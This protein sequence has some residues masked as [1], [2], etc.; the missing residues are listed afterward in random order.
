MQV[1]VPTP[2]NERRVLGAQLLAARYGAL[3]IFGSSRSMILTGAAGA[4]ISGNSRPVD[5]LHFLS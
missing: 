1:T 2:A 4:L 3:A 5:P